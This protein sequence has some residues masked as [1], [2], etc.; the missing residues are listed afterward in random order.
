MRLEATQGASFVISGHYQIASLVSFYSPGHPAVF[1]PSAPVAQ[2]QFFYWP[3]YRQA[4]HAGE[5]A[6]YVAFHD[7]VPPVL[8]RQFAQVRLLEAFTPQLAG[9]P[10][11]PY[12]ISLC[13]QLRPGAVP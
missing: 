3:D 5:N 4:R 10:L 13:E 8:G 12:Y 2:N 1:T 9:R 11:K 7:A 6:L